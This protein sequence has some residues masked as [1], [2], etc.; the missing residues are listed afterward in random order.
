MARDASR[1]GTRLQA[2]VAE[3]ALRPAGAQLEYR[4][5]PILLVDD[6]EVT[7]TLLQRQLELAGHTNVVATS[8]PSG[9]PAIFARTQPRL[10]LLDM[11]MPQIEGIELMERLAPLM[12]G[13]GSVPFLV[14]TSDM[15]E[16]A[17][18]R[19]LTV[20]ARDFLTKPLDRTE[21][22]LRVRNLLQ[23]QL[24]H[25]WL[26]AQ[27]ASLERQRGELLRDLEAMQAALV[28]TV[29]HQLE[30]LAVSVAYRPADG[31]AAGGD[32]YDLFVPQPGKVAI[33]IG[34]VC[35]HGREAL[36]HAVLTR[37]TLRA[38]V[39]AGMD[40][41]T[42]LALAGRVLV[43]K[44]GQRSA[45]VSLGVYDSATQ[46][47]TYALA[48]H[49]PP[50]LM[51]AGSLAM[52]PVTM[53]SSP[54]VGWGVAT[55]RRQTTVGLAGAQ[56]YFFS[57]GLLE[58]RGAGGLLGRERLHELIARLGPRPQA[59]ALLEAVRA[60]GG[61]RDDMVACVVASDDQ[62]KPG[63]VRV[64]ELEVDSRTV[65]QPVLARF[66]SACG[67][68]RPRIM[69]AIA[70]ARRIVTASGT[71]LLRVEIEPAGGSVSVTDGAVP[72]HT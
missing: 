69:R 41:R 11:H 60:G 6:D 33:M 67:V 21:L 50:V 26:F 38:Y 36:N 54:P 9:V 72:I 17:R 25:D 12:S 39:Q 71:A 24:R 40:P 1:P 58:A 59:E 3:H 66:L 30:G 53:C 55:G 37:Y 34:D 20:G 68:A 19:A 43:D 46:M 32:F 8:D 27:N 47:L 62:G 64:E 61:A 44:S 22:L 28:P 52:E 63:R 56:A 29:G 35:G 10:V 70:H 23:A 49:P 16:N 14:I 13:H 57:D 51:R 18:R 15:T 4:Q 5:L 2:T 7:L 65:A 31:P 48:G 42:C 45:T